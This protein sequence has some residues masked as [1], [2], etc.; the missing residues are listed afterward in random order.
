VPLGEPAHQVRLIKIWMSRQ[1]VRQRQRHGR[2]VG[3][4]ARAEAERPPAYH[5]RARRVAVPHLE[6]ERGADRI[7]HR[8]AEE[9]AHCPVPDGLA[10]VEGSGSSTSCSPMT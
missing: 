2:V 5:V 8:E 9:T 1:A 7:A 3:P 6:L 10:E 4:L